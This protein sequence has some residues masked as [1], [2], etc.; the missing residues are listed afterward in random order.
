MFGT[1]R[2][3]TERN[4]NNGLMQW[5]FNAREGVMGPYESK[6]RAERSLGAFKDRCV[7]LGDSGGRNQAGIE[8][9]LAKNAEVKTRMSNDW[10]FR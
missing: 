4:S 7:R 10:K 3:F 8:F 5:Y 9:S 6:E 2:I 1:S